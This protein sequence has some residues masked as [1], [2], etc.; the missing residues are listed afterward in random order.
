MHETLVETDIA[1]LLECFQ[2]LTDPR[3]ERC[4]LHQLVEVIVEVV[5]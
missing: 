5:Q 4:K 3:L 1:T 2:P